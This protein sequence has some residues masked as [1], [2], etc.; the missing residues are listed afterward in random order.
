MSRGCQPVAACE[1]APVGDRDSQPTAQAARP[2]ARGDAAQALFHPDRTDL[3]RL[4][5][6][7][8]PFS[9]DGRAGGDAPGG[10]EHRSVSERVGSKG[11]CNLGPTFMRYC[12]MAR[13][14]FPGEPA[15][16]LFVYQNW[17]A[18]SELVA[19]GVQS[20]RLVEPWMT[21]PCEA[22]PLTRKENCP[23]AAQAA[24]SNRNWGR[25][26][27]RVQLRVWLSRLVGS[28]RTNGVLSLTVTLTRL[29]PLPSDCGKSVKARLVS[30]ASA[31][32]FAV[33]WILSA[34][35][36]G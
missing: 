15:A 25:F 34:W 14:N 12:A 2:N 33:H 30:P 10:A 26:M 11:K 27:F 13:K 8:C 28:L 9:S 17:P 7:L 36:A 6:A 4:V 23:P 32:P 31:V 5:S 3:L 22:L 16:P 19:S 20:E 24:E 29:L 1:A 18:T 21:T 35:V